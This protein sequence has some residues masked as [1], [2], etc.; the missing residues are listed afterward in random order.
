MNLDVSEDGFGTGQGN[1]WNVLGGP[2]IGTAGRTFDRLMSV[3]LSLSR[4]SACAGVVEALGLE[5]MHCV[6]SLANCSK[7]CVKEEEC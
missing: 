1:G 4:P 5:P 2:R 6:L 7:E 3:S